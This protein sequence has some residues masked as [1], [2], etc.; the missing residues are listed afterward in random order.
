MR[1]HSIVNTHEEFVHLIFNPEIEV[2]SLI[3]VNNNTIF[4]E[5]RMLEDTLE[6]SNKSNV[7]LAAF[8]TAQAHLYRRVRSERFEYRQFLG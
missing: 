2:L 6:I 3:P 1:K 5:W 7:V 8:T 4:V